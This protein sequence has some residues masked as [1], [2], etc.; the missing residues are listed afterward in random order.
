MRN[1]A[2]WT[3]LKP[4]PN[5]LSPN[6][7]PNKPPPPTHTHPSYLHSDAHLKSWFGAVGPIIKGI[8]VF[9]A[10]LVQPLDEFTAGELTLAH[11]RHFKRE[12]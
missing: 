4:Q 8:A 7:S 10:E 1:N 6:S 11:I 12:I 3:P 2:A 9:D 5:H